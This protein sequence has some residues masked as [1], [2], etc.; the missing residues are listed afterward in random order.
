MR[1]RVM[2][3]R[4]VV[5]LVVASSGVLIRPE[6]VTGNFLGPADQ[7]PR[8]GLEL[9]DVHPLFGGEAVLVEGSGACVIRVVRKG[10]EERY[11]LKLASDEALSLWKLCI[12]NDLLGVEVPQRVGVMDEARPEITLRNAA[13]QTRSVVKW[14]RQK[15]QGFDSVYEALLKLVDKTETLKPG[16]EG[17]YEPGWKPPRV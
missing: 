8:C 17:K 5:L 15:V 4:L 13:G 9:Q 10:Q 2:L 14:A 12:G 16:Y 1:T 3:I 7:W 6:N 11:S